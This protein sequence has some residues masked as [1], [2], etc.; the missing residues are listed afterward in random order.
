MF[1][2]LAAR[3]ALPRRD[4]GTLSRAPLTHDDTLEPRGVLDL[5]YYF[6]VALKSIPSLHGPAR[7]ALAARV[8][9]LHKRGTCRS[10]GVCCPCLQAQAAWG[11]LAPALIQQQQ[12]EEGGALSERHQQAVGLACC[13]SVGCG[14]CQ[15]GRR[16]CSGQHSRNSHTTAHC[17]QTCFFLAR[18]LGRSRGA[19][20]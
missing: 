14:L 20:I 12:N 11:R 7:S 6:A 8:L 4:A 15:P 2:S 19:L 17:F 3:S 13:C 16:R 5:S 10:E 1:G 9:F 18:P